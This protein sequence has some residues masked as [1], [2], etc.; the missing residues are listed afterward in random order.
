MKRSLKIISG[1][2]LGA[3]WSGVLFAG[4]VT[5]TFEVA[6]DPLVDPEFTNALVVGSHSY[7]YGTPNWQIWSSGAGANVGGNPGGYFSISDA[8]NGGQGLAFV[9]PDI[10][11]GAPLKGFVMDMDVRAGN[12]TLGRPADG[13]SI[14]FARSGDQ[15]LV[16]A[17]N[18]VYNGF[19][20]GD[21]LATAQGTAG[22]GDAENGTKTGVSIV[23]DAWQGN[24]L[25]DTPPNNGV[26]GT[27]N[28][29]EGIAVR[30]DDVTLIQLNLI[31]NRNGVDCV[32][33]PQTTLADNGSGLSMQTGTNS[34]VLTGSGCTRTYGATDA[35]GTYAN[36]VWQPL[37]VQLVP[38]VTNTYNVHV[39]YK[40]TLVLDTNLPTY[41]AFEGR[42]VLAGRTGGNNQNCHIDNIH[43]VTLPSTNATLL[44]IVGLLNGF[45]F[46]IQ[47]KTNGGF[48]SYLTNVTSAKFDGVEEIASP[49]MHIAYSTVTGDPNGLSVGVYTQAVFLVPSSVHSV[50]LA[51]KDSFGASSFGNFTFTVPPWL[52]LPPSAALPLSAVDLTKPGF[53]I[54][55][56]QTLQLQPNQ[57]R[58]NEEMVA[59]LHGPNIVG[60]S[61]GF[62]T[63]NGALVWNGPLDFANLGA[64]AP[65]AVGSGFFPN[66][67]L[68]SSLDAMGIGK[69]Y[70]S[71]AVSGRTAYSYADNSAM[72]IF[73]YVYF[74]TSGLYNLVIGSDDGY[75]LTVSGNPR[76]RMGALIG[77]LNGSLLPTSAASLSF[78][79]IHPTVV[80]VPG[81]YP[82][83]LLWENGGGGCG[84]EV[85][86][87]PNFGVTAVPGV[88]A[89][90]LNDTNNTASG[91]ALMAF[92]AL[93]AGQSS[94]PYVSKAVPVRD[95]MDVFY[96]QKNV[97][98]L[99]DGSLTVASGSVALTV[100]GVATP[101]TVTTPGGGITHIVETAV[102]NRTVG[103]H[104]N[105][106]SF[107]D[108]LANNYAYTWWFTVMGTANGMAAAD[109]TNTPAMIPVANRVDPS[110]LSTPGFTVNSHQMLFKEPNVSGTA[111]LELQ[112]LLGPNIAVILGQ[113]TFH[114]NTPMDYRFA[115]GT[116]AGGGAAGEWA[117]DNDMGSAT[118]G[119]Q[120]QRGSS[121]GN[122]IDNCVLEIGCYLNF[123]AA[124]N[125][126]MNLNSDDGGKVTSPNSKYLFDKMGTMLGFADVGRGIAGPPGG[127]PNGG[128]P[129]LINIPAAGA[130]PFR[131]VWENGGGD[132]ALE[133]SVWVP[134]AD[135][136]VVHEL[137]NDPSAPIPILAS[138]V[139][140]VQPGPYVSYA[141]PT[142]HQQGVPWFAPP[143][144]KITDGPALTTDPT[145]I[146]ALLDDGVATTFSVPPK[147]GSVTTVIQQLD[148]NNPQVFGRNHTNTLIFHDSAGT[149]YTNRWSY[150]VVGT[151]Q[152]SDAST[153]GTI[154]PYNLVTVPASLT[155]PIASLD[156]TQPGFRIK[157]YMTANGNNNTPVFTE[158]QFAGM[159]GPNLAV[160]TP[161]PPAGYWT[162]TNA[163]DFTISQ[164]NGPN[165]SS[166]E[167]NYDFA[168]TN[169]GTSVF[170][171]L[172]SPL[173]G[174]GSVPESDFGFVNN[175]PG[176]TVQMNNC[177]LMI[178][179]YLVF[180]QN[181][182]Y[183]MTVGSDDCFK[184]TVPYGG[185][186]W[187][188]SGLLVGD[189]NAGRGSAGAGFGS[190][191]GQTWCP[192][193][194]TNA[195][196]AIPFRLLYE[197][198]GGGGGVEFNIWQPLADGSVAY[199]L[200]ND[201]FNP[202]SIQAFQTTT[203]VQ[204]PYVSFMNPQP[205]LQYG[206]QRPDFALSQNNTAA[207]TG[208]NNSPVS[209]DFVFGLSNAGTGVDTN[210][211]MSLT[212]M[213]IAQPFLLAVSNNTLYVTRPANSPQWWPSGA[214]GPLVFNYTDSS[215][216]AR[217]INLGTVLTPFWGTLATGS[218]TLQDQN[219]PGF[220]MR[221]Y[222][223]DDLGFQ[224]MNN[225][226]HNAEQ[227]LTGIWGPN[228]VNP[229]NNPTNANVGGYFIY[230]GAGPSNGVV[231]FDFTAGSADGNF[232]APNF[233]AFPWPGI[234]SLATGN[235][236]NSFVGEFLSY[237][238][239]PSNGV[240]TLGVSSDDGFRLISGWTP[241]SPNGA[242]VVNS[243]A[244]LA[245]SKAAAQDPT[246]SSYILTNT[247]TANLAVAYGPYTVSSNAP[248]A[249]PNE[250]GSTNF[251]G[252]GFSV[253]GCLINSSANL[254]GKVALIFRSP[255]CATQQRVANAQAMGAVGVV[256]VNYPTVYTNGAPSQ[257]PIEVD[258]NTPP[259]NI[260]HM[261]IEWADGLKLLA[262]A[263]TN[264]PN[265][266]LT[267]IQFVV[268][269]PAG[270]DVLGQAD[271]GKGA[272]DVLFPVVVSQAGTYPL[273]LTWFQ[274]GGGANCEFFQVVNGT[275]IL[276]NDT[277]HG[278]PLNAYWQLQTAVV[279]TIK[280]VNNLNGTVTITFTGVLQSESNLTSH[281]WVDVAGSPTSPYTIP[282]P[283][284]ATPVYYRASSGP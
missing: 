81:V 204:P 54:K 253:D 258:V 141:N 100:D 215:A 275:R 283:P 52:V 220:K 160:G 273:R 22:S 193:V 17:T 276:V 195:P 38:T 18:G 284:T 216:Q 271:F 254:A 78:S 227:A 69:N 262:A 125:Y 134:Q 198:G 83:R 75:E 34:F 186:I 10:D 183:I 128:T 123:P 2:L 7:A 66:A 108:N 3:A 20:G 255:F 56:Y 169:N 85:Y 63:E 131:V 257:L 189:C 217:V 206:P 148:P 281:T 154:A 98:E 153:P 205:P 118:F 146:D 168:W 279:P 225:R 124:G 278:S 162:W 33:T 35:S 13:F 104:T 82:I 99:T 120:P 86:T 106:L 263:Q 213:G 226:Y 150:S 280:I 138:Q 173:M 259:Q 93:A 114:F 80:S 94:P 73:S 39:T 53:L 1:A 145:R 30:I 177:S 57:V 190:R 197:N 91:N 210:Q 266:S 23:F 223:L 29:R 142:D 107:Q 64:V 265:V 224:D 274:G 127:V 174:N 252:L 26:A 248:Y 241:P 14:S 260:P 50:S 170:D 184:L 230:P 5:Y 135:G 246:C 31:N 47:D 21:D 261:F 208:T 111:E 149:S 264:P 68:N 178:G 192:F 96:N 251:Q 155:V 51:W 188:M 102:P 90:L 191:G 70:P 37:H 25:A 238:T 113:N 72:E 15:V 97:I 244:A 119:F 65:G 92:R 247:V 165:S 46:T 8:T 27:S 176:T 44:N 95:A 130:Y 180:Q 219:S 199:M 232:N 6:P 19:A 58:W 228:V 132:A 277:V 268:N 187:N 55:P 77:T 250:F 137:I 59:G 143:I 45:Q 133:W 88:N 89:F 61:T 239:F 40:G 122:N 240:Y 245:G 9:F 62:T 218:V 156:L 76:D 71:G 144:V 79:A 74:P 158:Q 67:D 12:G 136:T 214:F 166:A 185:N 231:N 147:V 157:S 4:N 182:T 209:Q 233:P 151:G 172:V 236:Q 256:I 32:P 272:S 139:S 60:A 84:L 109:P 161:T 48:A 41:N 163:I 229:A 101:T 103:L 42:L 110:T 179:A 211:P 194:V 212:F 140:S 202:G 16:N 203:A 181:G 24:F 164:L 237:V 36:L 112:G 49:N 196:C 222:A 117:V 243:P 121:A 221:I 43:L 126:L 175:P 11:A 28:D 152:G 105:V 167:W 270:N 235:K 129:F 115:S 200:V 282:V 116:G 159:Q 234:N 171:P 249:A 267:P 201:Q 207:V 242:L 269:P 87:A